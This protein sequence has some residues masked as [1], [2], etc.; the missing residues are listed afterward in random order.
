MS[1]TPSRILDKH[2]LNGCEEGNG[3]VF[4]DKQRKS[5]WCLYFIDKST[6][7]R[8]RIVLKFPDGRYPEPTSDGLRDAER[9]GLK[10]FF[11]MKNKTDRGEKLKTLSIKKMTEMFIEEEGKRVSEIPHSG[12]TKA[13]FRLLKSQ[14][15][16]YLDFVMNKEWGLGKAISSSIHLMPINHLDSYLTYRLKTTGEKDKKGRPL[17][18]K[19]TI[20][21]E[22]STIH[23]MYEIIGVSKRFI[24]RNSLPIKPKLKVT[25]KETQDIRQSMFSV[26]EY[27]NLEQNAR[28]YFIHG[29]SRFDPN[30]GEKFGY[31][32]YVRG[33]NKGEDNPNK[34]IRKSILFGNGKSARA[35]QQLAHR[36]IIYYGI[37]I[38][39][40]TGIRIGSLQQ[41]KWS[42]IDKLPRR[43][44]RDE[45]VYRLLKVRAEEGKTARY[46]EIPC[47]I[48]SFCSEIKRVS[49]FTKPDDYIF[50][51]QN[52]GKMFSWRIWSENLI[53]MMIEADLAKL[54]PKSSSNCRSMIV[55]TGKDLSWYSFRHS[56]ITWRLNAGMN[57][58]EVAAYCDT[59]IEYI[60]KHYYHPDIV[61]EKMIENLELGRFTKLYKR[62]RDDF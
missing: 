30:T 55:N 33:K 24:N 60:Q 5:K 31:E 32:K 9:L 40:E 21:S 50:A 46:Y 39:M 7:D 57:I 18:R 45:K 15:V 26:S 3:Y 13:R 22:I 29:L 20:K 8:H 53:D 44:N 34:P 28:D 49:K 56:F 59:S 54:N 19:Q 62:S 41:L 23:R 17:P 51:N 2:L 52:T 37:R 14:C 36:K 16:H 10:L 4:R 25:T 42:N 12:I 43:S 35:I 1:A 27:R 58:Q 48:A 38:T 11:E 47:P 6:R 61:D